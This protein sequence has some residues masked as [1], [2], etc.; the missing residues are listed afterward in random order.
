V[1][2]TSISPASIA[3][4]Y[5]FLRGEDRNVEAVFGQPLVLD[6]ANHDANLLT[7]QILKPTNRRSR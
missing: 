6:G 1:A 5:V 7:V 2:P 4:I 3:A